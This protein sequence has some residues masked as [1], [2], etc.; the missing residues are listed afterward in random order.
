MQRSTQPLTSIDYITDTI[1]SELR[2]S[3]E[4]DAQL[5]I[6]TACCGLNELGAAGCLLEVF[7]GLKTRDGN[8]VDTNNSVETRLTVDT[9]NE[10]VRRLKLTETRTLLIAFFGEDMFDSGCV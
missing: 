5:L 10:Q 2:C 4:S 8:S 1:C 7:I 6:R 9:I 3:N